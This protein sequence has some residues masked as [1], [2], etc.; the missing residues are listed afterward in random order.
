MTPVTEAERQTFEKDVLEGLQSDPMRLPPKYFYDERGSRLFDQISELDEYYPTRTELEIM[1]RHVSE[2]VDRIGPHALLVEFG[3]GNSKKTRILL[4]EMSDPAGYIPVDISRAYLQESAAI[5]RQA[6][7]DLE[8]RPVSADYTMPIALPRLTTVP[9]RI[10][11]YFPGSTIGNLEAYD[12]HSFLLRTAALGG[13]G[14]GLLI[15]LDLKKD[16]STLERAYNDRSGVTEAFNKNLL[17][18]MNRELGANFDTDAFDHRAVYNSHA[19]RIEMY[20]VSNRDQEVRVAGL[21]KHL[22]RG[23]RICTEHSYKYSIDEFEG[24][25]NAAGFRVDAVWTDPHKWF[26]VQYCTVSDL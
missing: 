17:V 15:G 20:L 9:A 13:P 5:L 16:I 10:V 14:G 2:M 21:V 24:L 23:D 18:R 26:S 6:Y 12:A 11:V 8:I 1:E 25:V 3:S 4:D 19:G 22:K 7:P